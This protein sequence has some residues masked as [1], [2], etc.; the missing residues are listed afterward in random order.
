MTNGPDVGP[1][2]PHGEVARVADIFCNNCGHRNSTGSNF[3]SSCGH[4]LERVSDDPSTITFS[5][6]Q[7]PGGEEISVELDELGPGGVLVATR[8]P[9]AGSEFA[10]QQVITT[11][12]RHPDSDIFLDDVTVSRRHAEV[13]RISNGY[14]VRDVGSLN[15]T[16]VNQGRIEGDTPLTNGDEVQVGRFKLVFVA[17]ADA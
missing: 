17:G 1:D 5:L 2:P 7:Q 3:C 10:L 8:G 16:Y 6:D 12:G 9:N 15:G 13:E 11:A 14:V 4:P